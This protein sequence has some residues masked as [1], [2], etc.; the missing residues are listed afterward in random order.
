MADPREEMRIDEE[1]TPEQVEDPVQAET[2]G[3]VRGEETREPERFENAPEEKAASPEEPQAAP[4][5][6]D[7][8]RSEADYSEERQP[9]YADAH[10]EPAGST[11]TPPRY[12]TPPVRQERVKREKPPRKARKRVALSAVICLCLV[13][14]LLG[15]C[16]GAGLSTWSSGARLDAMEQ[17]LEENARQLAENSSAIARNSAAISNAGSIVPAASVQSAVSGTGLYSLSPAQIYERAC[18]QVVGITVK[19]S[20]ASYF[21]GVQTGTVSGSGFIISEDGYI[22]TNYHVVQMADGTEL[23]ITVML[24]DGTEYEA[25]IVGTEDANDLAVL[26]IDAEGLSPAVFGD[27]DELQVGEEIYV[28]GNPLGELEFSMS[29]GHVSAL[30]RV[31]STEGANSISMFQLDAAVNHGNSGGP[32]YNSRGEVVGVVTAKY[33]DYDVEGLGCAI[34]S[35]DTLRI[36][37][38]LTTLGYVSGKAYLGIGVDERYNAIMAQYY[39]MPLGAYVGSVSKDSAADHAGL[40]KGDIITRIDDNEIESYSDLKQALRRY[41]AGDS[42]ELGF[43]RAGESKSVTIVFDERTPETVAQV[44]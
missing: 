33:S 10:Y 31:I 40:Q 34:P 2:A 15:G 36:T 39:N 19:Y 43:Y 27:S 5:H 4:A 18:S 11:T 21:G 37:Q 22:V 23:P 24:H 32:V 6:A 9:I 13:C 20:A 44:P 38:D 41:A 26:K 28:V 12:Y 25:S 3:F 16:L 42:A 14:G 30:N 35:S 29:T 17:A 1:T 7:W 8:Y